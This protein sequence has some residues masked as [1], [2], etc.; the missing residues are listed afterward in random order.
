MRTLALFLAALLVLKLA[1]L[2]LEP[3]IAFYPTTGV[4]TTPAAVSLPFEDLRIPTRDGETLHGWWLEHPQPR[5][6]VVFW[7]GNGGNLSLWMDVV[8]DCDDGGSVC[9]Q[10]ITGAT[11]S[12]PGRPASRASTATPRPRCASSCAGSGAPAS[13]S[14]TGAARLG[15]RSRRRASRSSVPTRSCSRVRCRTHARWCAATRSCC[16]SAISRPTVRNIAIPRRLRRAAARH[17]RRCRQHRPLQRG[18]AGVQGRAGGERG[19]RHDSRRGSQ[20]SARGQARPV[21]A[22]DRSIRGGAR[23]DA[24][25]DGR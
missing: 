12:A 13:P 18:S 3:K 8:V 1:V 17:S 20:R 21:L 14:S 16:S 11:G 22:R 2:W 25:S 4:Q 23:H 5:A 15:R 9:W 10:S 24:A 6:Q 19:V 7:H